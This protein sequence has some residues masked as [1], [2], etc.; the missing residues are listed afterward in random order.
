METKHEATVGEK[1]MAE[2]VS[3]GRS[4]NRKLPRIPK[5]DGSKYITGDAQE[6][7]YEYTYEDVEVALRLEE[8]PT[9]PM[10]TFKQVYE[11]GVLSEMLSQMEMNFGDCV[12]EK[13][14][15]RWMQIIKRLN[16]V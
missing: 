9:E 14:K 13:A 10:P 6:W 7:T 4:L 3:V 11:F 1:M 16:D 8:C 15:E 5:K 2:T 12:G